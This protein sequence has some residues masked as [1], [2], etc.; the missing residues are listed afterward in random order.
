MDVVSV[1]GRPL[2][3]LSLG[4]APFWS[5]FGS[6][7][8]LLR[9]CTSGNTSDSCSVV[10]LF[11]NVTFSAFQKHIEGWIKLLEKLIM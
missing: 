3:I 6:R 1:E 10:T 11:M 8:T 4:L 5:C 9:L 7:C 2:S